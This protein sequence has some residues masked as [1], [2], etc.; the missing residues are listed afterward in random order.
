MVKK[1]GLDQRF[2][3]G[4]YDLSG[5]VSSINDCSSPIAVLEVPSLANSA[6][7]RVR[8]LAD[9]QMEFGVWFNKATDQEHLALRGL[10]L[11]DVVSLWSMGSAQ[12]SPAAMLVGKQ[13]NYDWNRGPDGSLSGVVQI[14]SSAGR[15]IEYGEMF[16]AFDDLQASSGNTSSKDDAALSSDGL[17]AVLEVISIDSG[18]PTCTIE[19][20][21]DDAVFVTLVAFTAIVDGTEPIAERVEVAGTVNRYL[22]LA[23]T[24]TFTNVTYALA[25]RRGE[26]VDTEAYV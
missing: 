22:R 8:G 5:D 9:G 13:V 25:Y 4:G 7:E 16:S 26:T 10:P 6:M 21:T 3:I 14:V 18:T 1:S 15:S 17:A 19:D 11:T 20:S 2:Y 23:W 24:G 12:G